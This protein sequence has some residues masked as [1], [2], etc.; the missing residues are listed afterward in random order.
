MCPRWLSRRSMAGARLQTRCADTGGCHRAEGAAEGV[1]H[2][3]RWAGVWHPASARGSLPGQVA[4][5]IRISIKM[6]IYRQC[7]S[8]LNV[9]QEEELSK[10]ATQ[11]G[12]AGGNDLLAEILVL[13]PSPQSPAPGEAARPT[14]GTW[15]A[16]LLLK[17][18]RGEKLTCAGRG[19]PSKRRALERAAGKLGGSRHVPARAKLRL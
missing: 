4:Q 17:T 15:V 9:S 19:L 8:N 10:K 14:P 3:C 2:G 18:S 5:S 1:H 16:Q 6:C 12:P 7:K 13:M 11:L